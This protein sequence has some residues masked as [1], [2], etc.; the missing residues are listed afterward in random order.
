MNDIMKSGM[1]IANIAVP[2][3]TFHKWFARIARPVAP[4]EE[5]SFG[6]TKQFTPTA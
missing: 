5:I 1:L 6:D 3:G 4:P 2:M